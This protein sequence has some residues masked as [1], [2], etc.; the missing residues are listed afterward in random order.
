MVDFGKL[1]SN[2]GLLHILEQIL[3]SLD[4][5]DIA[6]CRVLS[7][8]LKTFIDNNKSLNNKIRSFLLSEIKKLIIQ[9]KDIINKLGCS[10]DLRSGL[11]S[12]LGHSNECIRNDQAPGD[13]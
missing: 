7:R 10:E 5:N 13:Q 3:H 1:I 6:K 12:I 4:P 9:R 11:C 2:P 8:S